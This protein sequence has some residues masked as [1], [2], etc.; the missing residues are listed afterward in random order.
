MQ[1]FRDVID[2]CNL[3]DMG[4]SGENFTW[5]RGRIRE[6]LD[7]ALVN[8]TWSQMYPNA[9]LK[10]LDFTRSDHRPILLD[11]E[12][13]NVLTPSNRGPKRFEARWLKEDGF[14]TEVEHAWKEAGDVAGTTFLGRLSHMHAALHAWDHRVLKKPKRRLLKAQWELEKAMNGP[15]NND[16]ETKAKEMA[17]LIELLLE[18]D[19][20][21]WAQRSRANWLQ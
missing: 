15:M 21:Y 18:Q 4:F 19:E 10:H 3:H 20:V 13:Q 2:D 6:R 5:K 12:N 11:T 14:R 9:M 1:A 17:N 8:A 7:H 16:N